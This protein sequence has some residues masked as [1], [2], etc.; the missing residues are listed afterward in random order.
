MVSDGH[1]NEFNTVENIYGDDCKL[2]KLDCV[3]HMQ[4][5]MGKHLLNHKGRTKGKLA[6]GKPI[7]E[8]S[9]LTKSRIKC[10]QKYYGLAISQNTLSKANPTEREV[11][12]AV[13]T[14][15]KNII[16]IFHHSVQ[17]QDAAKQHSFCPVSEVS[18]CKWQQDCATGTTTY[19]A[20]DCFPEVFFELL[21][22]TLTTLCETQ[23]LQ[24]CVRCA[25]QN[26]NECIYGLVWA[27]CP[28]KQAS[29]CQGDS[30]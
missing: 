8:Q 23:L 10:L 17:S 13:S 21:K 9:R 4:N 2:E 1:S 26:R 7:G 22:P 30:M 19:D 25:T 6:D 3:G 11:D 20:G 28:K 24:R 5:C 29:W 12:V 15:K 18:W 16:A 27:R 14:M